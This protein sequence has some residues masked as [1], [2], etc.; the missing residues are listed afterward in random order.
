MTQYEAPKLTGFLSTA[1]GWI[2]RALILAAI[3]LLGRS[4]E[5]RS[6]AGSDVLTDSHIPNPEDCGFVVD[7]GELTYAQVGTIDGD[8]HIPPYCAP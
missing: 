7:E 6:E 5:V 4:S 2:A 8:G 1:G 3:V